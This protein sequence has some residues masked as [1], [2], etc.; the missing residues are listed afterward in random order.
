MDISGKTVLI[1]GGAKGIGRV[2]VDK[3]IKENA[4]VGVLDIDEKP[5]HQLSVDSPSIF[6]RRCDITDPTQVELALSDYIK[7]FDTIDILINVAGLVK[8]SPL[9]SIS[10]EIKR[11]DLELWNKII[12]VNLTSVF[13]VSSYVAEYM[14]KKRT[15][16]LIINVSSVSSNGNAGQ[17]AYSAAKAGVIALTKTWA[18]ELNGLGIR[19]ASISPGFTR[20]D[21]LLSIMNEKLISE[22]SKKIPLRRMAQPSEIADGILFIIHNDYFNGKT[23]ELDGGLIV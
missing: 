15:K 14:I 3:L 9:I 19:V 8:D 18:K 2:L 6:V 1:T 21:T 4:R 10:G 5:L 13:I 16:G 11:H 22:W 20:T 17:S 12:S 23:L 7:D